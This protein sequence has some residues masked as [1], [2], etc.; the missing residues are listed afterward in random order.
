[1]LAT[2]KNIRYLGHN[3]HYWWPDPVV[4]AQVPAKV[5]IKVKGH[6]EYQWLTG[7]YDLEQDILRGD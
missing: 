7:G 2:S 1:M 4:I 6:R 3:H 5:I